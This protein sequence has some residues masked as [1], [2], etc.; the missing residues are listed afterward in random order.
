ME[1]S[2]CTVR[3]LP[4]IYWKWHHYVNGVLI[5][6]WNCTYKY[7]E[8]LERIKKINNN[9]YKKL[10][11]LL[12]EK[13][14]NLQCFG[15][16]RRHTRFFSLQFWHSWKENMVIGRV[17]TSFKWN[18]IEPYKSDRAHIY[19]DFHCIESEDWQINSND[20]KQQLNWHKIWRTKYNK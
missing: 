12:N 3:N 18:Q 10:Q 16:L 19:N 8:K 14:K 7:E 1:I 2:V 20:I 17:F 5:E 11:Q 13:K 15:C 9:K 6:P 4:H